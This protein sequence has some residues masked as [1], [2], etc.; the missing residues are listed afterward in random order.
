ME[1]ARCPGDT[2]PSLRLHKPTGQGRVILDGRHV[3]LGEFGSPECDARYEVIVRKWRL[4]Q[5]D[6]A[7]LTIDVLAIRYLEHAGTYYRR[8]DGTPT[9]EAA[10]IRAAIR[11]LVDE[12]GTT[13]V[14]AFTPIGPDCRPQANG[15]RGTCP[16]DDWWADQQ[17]SGR[18]QVGRRQRILPR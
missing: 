15:G 8:A 2:P 10:N 3:Y 9:G 7:N 4:A 16:L 13:L 14:R 12:F 1:V 5:T 18:V 11:P 6:P 17:D